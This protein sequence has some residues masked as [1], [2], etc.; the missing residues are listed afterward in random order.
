M[1]HLPEI[2]HDL[3]S[4]DD[5]NSEGT[6]VY[7]TDANTSSWDSSSQEPYQHEAE[8]EEKT[9]SR[10]VKTFRDQ[11]NNPTKKRKYENFN[12]T[13]KI[14][15]NNLIV[16]KNCGSIYRYQKIKSPNKNKK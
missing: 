14:N 8:S 15:Q 12:D 7:E 6:E 5:D 4:D 3:Q 2:H 16:C 1:A 13:R 11:Q 10:S 9:L